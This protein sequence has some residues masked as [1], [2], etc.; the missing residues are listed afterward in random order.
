MQKQCNS[1]G[2]IH[3]YT[4]GKGYKERIFPIG[5][6]QSMNHP[7]LLFLTAK[8]CWCRKSAAWASPVSTSTDIHTDSEEEASQLPVWIWIWICYIPS[9]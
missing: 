3:P 6:H 4:E 1:S 9:L 8:S 2:L 5:S 7:F